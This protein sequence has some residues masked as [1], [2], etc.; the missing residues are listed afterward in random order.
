MIAAL[1]FATLA[2]PPILEVR[3]QS[4][5]RVTIQAIFKLPHMEPLTRAEADVLARIVTGDNESYSK[6]EMRDLCL[7]GGEPKGAAMPD[8]LSIR[9][10][11]LPA[12]TAAGMRMLAAIAKSARLEPNAM[13]GF[14]LKEPYR[15]RSVWSEALDSEDR[16]WDRLRATDITNL[17]HLVFRPDNVTIAVG[18]AVKPGAAQAAWKEATASWTKPRSLPPRAAIPFKDFPALYPSHALEL[19]GPEW[20]PTDATFPAKLLALIALGSGKASTLFRVVREEKA[21]SYRQ[22]AVLWPTAEGLVP[23]LII[24]IKPLAAEV[25]TKELADIRTILQQDID[26]WDD[27]TLQRAQGFA[28][29][30]ATQGMD[31][32]PLYL[33]G[34]YALGPSIEDRTFLAAYW[35]F[36]TG[37]PWDGPTMAQAMKTIDLPTL[38]Q[39]A[40][41]LITAAIPIVHPKPSGSS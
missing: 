39:E 29:A 7:P 4:A 22:E 23:R 41:S 38:K 31:L 11:V 18:G 26:H 28:S 20:S 16:A 15:H 35:K 3:D 8:H 37:A 33:R 1:V 34:P 30:I 21:L 13:N 19:R 5:D 14:L 6:Q 40:T 27:A 12:D 17:Y 24:Q 32:S 10:S 25:E 2:G 36:K 9:L